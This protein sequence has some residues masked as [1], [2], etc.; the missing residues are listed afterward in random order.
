LT[1]ALTTLTDYALAAASVGFAVAIGRSIGPR[2]R[3][4]AWLWC[5]AFIAAALA[6]AAGGTY[7]G[8]TRQL[9]PGT[10]RGLWNFT[11]FAMGAS[12]AFMTAGIHAAHIRRADG[13]VAWLAGGIAVT[14]FGGAVQQGALP[15]IASLNRNA[16]YHAIQIV[17]L[18]LFFRCALTVRDRRAAAPE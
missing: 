17:A 18:Y 11:M 10:V 9:A 12:G 7:H 15:G 13:T 4:S 5:A 16:A 3:V 1:E 2:T 14:A 6:A 8:F